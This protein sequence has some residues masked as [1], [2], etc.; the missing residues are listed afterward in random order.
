MLFDVH[1]MPDI[2]SLTA[3]EYLELLN[4][5]LASHSQISLKKFE[6]ETSFQIMFC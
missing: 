1:G 4:F 5:H 6:A 2:L 3:T